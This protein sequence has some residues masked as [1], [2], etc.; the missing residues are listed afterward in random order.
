[1]GKTAVIEQAVFGKHSPGQ[2]SVNIRNRLQIAITAPWN[3]LK[4][5]HLDQ[6][7]ESIS[8]KTTDLSVETEYPDTILTTFCKAGYAVR[9]NSTIK[10]A[11]T[12]LRWWR[13]R[14]SRAEE[15]FPV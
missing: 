5:G 11:N 4:T 14:L 7:K 6:K 1:M 9:E 12:T 13:L 8:L 2:V 3:I 10:L 15:I